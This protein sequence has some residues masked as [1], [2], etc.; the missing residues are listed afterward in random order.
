MSEILTKGLPANIETEKLV[1]GAIL[2]DDAVYSQV[3][4]TISAEDFAIEKHRRLWLRMSEIHERGERIDRVTLANELGRHH[5]LESVDGL[6]Y[7]VS[8]DDGM[9]TVP[10]LDSYVRIIK[11]KSALRSTIF[12]AQ[13]IIDRCVLAEEESETIL[14]GAREELSKIGDS[15]STGVPPDIGE[16]VTGYAGGFNAF[17]DPS[18]RPKG[19]PTGF[20]KFDEMTGGLHNGDMIILAGRPSTGKS[21]MAGNIAQFVAMKMEVGVVIFSLEMSKESLV[22]RMICGTARVDQQKFRAGYL[23]HDERSRLQRAA[24]DLSD[25]PLHIDDGSSVT[26][27]DIHAKVRRLQQDKNIGLVI[28]D[29]LQLMGSKGKHENRNQEVT[30]MSRGFKLMAKEFNI[31]VIVLSQLNRASEL[32]TGDHRPKISDL[33][34]SGAIEQD[35]DVIGLIFREEMHKRDREDLRGLA[36]LILDKS[37]NGPTGTIKL[38]FLREFARFDNRTNDLGYDEAEAAAV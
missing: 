1:L 9:P 14:A 30:A 36:E 28:V 29:Y 35:A 10:N 8:L 18:R 23:N 27:M 21:A 34:E 15:K 5:Q 19:I 31:P 2:L 38:V 7:L 20:L 22:T 12:A 32:R 13:K 6:S 25:A 26:L 24:V 4:D 3:A 11:E 16:I 37:R 33:R 17:L